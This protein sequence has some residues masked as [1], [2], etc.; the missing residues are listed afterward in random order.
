[1][2]GCDLQGEEFGSDSDCSSDDLIVDREGEENYIE[3]FDS[4]HE[5]KRLGSTSNSKG[6]RKLGGSA[7]N[8]EN[9]SSRRGRPRILSSGSL[10]NKQTASV[11]K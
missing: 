4:Y 11:S 8:L 5:E 10:K 6:K 1:M 3:G 7:L 9:Q 2:H